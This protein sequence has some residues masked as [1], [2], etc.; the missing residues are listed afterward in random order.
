MA[1]VTSDAVFARARVITGHSV[2]VVALSGELDVSTIPSV[3]ATVDSAIASALA[4]G[5][6]LV[7]D[8]S[9]VSF[10][11]SSGIALLLASRA[12]V[13]RVGLRQPTATIA[14]LL[15]IAGL[16]EVLPVIE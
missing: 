16:S 15:E 6:H 1:D 4:T 8:L 12:R 14:R 2:P 5:E 9:G 10:M 11:D 3:Q 13:G 7:F